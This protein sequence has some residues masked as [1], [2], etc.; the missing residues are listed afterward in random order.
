MS[1]TT[2]IIL[3]FTCIHLFWGRTHAT[4]CMWW[5]EGNLQE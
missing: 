1:H 5:S 2:L 3:V 4:V